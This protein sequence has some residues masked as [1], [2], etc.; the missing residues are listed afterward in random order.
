MKVNKKFIASATSAALVASAIVPVA[1]AAS[2]SDIENNTHKDAILALA[3]AGIISGYTD[4]T[5]K[6]NAQVTR[7]NVTKLLGKWLVTEGYEIP[8]DYNTV[9]RFTDVPV[10]HAD[11]ELV[12]YAALV[13]DAEV[14]NGSNGKLMQANNMSR[15]QMAVVLV[16]AIKTVYGIDLI[17][18]YKAANFESEITDF[19]QAIADYHESIT[20][21]EFAGLT[22]QKTF[23]PKGTVTR[24][25]FASF[26][27]RAIEYAAKQEVAETVEVESVT[28]VNGTLTVTLKEKAEK[29]DVK[30]FTVTQAINGG[31][32]K[33]VTPSKVELA[34][35]GLTVTLTVDKVAQTEA[36]QSVVYTVNKVAAEAFVVD[37]NKLKVESVSAINETTVQVTLAEVPTETPVADDFTVLV[38]GQKVEVS[39]VAK[40]PNTTDK[41]N[42]TIATLKGKEGSLEV[43]GKA[44]VI[45]GSEFGYDFKL[46][47]VVSVEGVDK[48]HVKVT[49]SEKVDKTTAETVATYELTGLDGAQLSGAGSKAPTAATLSADGKSVLLTTDGTMETFSNGY[50]LNVKIGLKDAKGQA[51][52][53]AIKTIFSGNG[54]ESTVAPVAVRAL[55]NPGTKEILVSF[56]KKIASPDKTKIK[57]AGQALTLA[58]SVTV[59]SGDATGRTLKI[60]L[61]TATATAFEASADQTVAFEA[62]AVKDTATTANA[63]EASSVAVVSAAKLTTATYNEET[64]KLVL[65]FTQPV[66]TSSLELEK[67]EVNGQTLAAAKVETTGT[68]SAVTIDLTTATNL[69]NIEQA[70]ETDRKVEL[71]TPTPGKNVDVNGNEIALTTITTTSGFTYTDDVTLPT[72]VGASVNATTKKLVIEFSEPVTVTT[73]SMIEIYDGT[74]KLF[75]LGSTSNDVDSVTPVKNTLEVS[76]KT[77]ANP[78]GIDT[79]KAVEDKSKLSVKVLKTTAATSGTE[80]VKDAAGNKFTH[81]ADASVAL[82]YTDQDAVQVTA[83]AQTGLASNQVKVTFD[84]PVKASDL[85]PSNFVVAKSDNAAVTVP[86]TKVIGSNNNK[87]IILT[88]DKDNANFVHGYTYAVKPNVKDIYE[89]PVTATLANN[90]FTLDTAVSAT[91]PALTGAKYEDA[92]GNFKADQGDTITL[93]YSAAVEITGD[94]TADELVL[95]SAIKLGTGFTV[96]QG[97]KVEEVVV[98]LGANAD[99]N[100]EDQTADNKKINYTGTAENAHIKGVN[101]KEAVGK[102][103]YSAAQGI[104]LVKPDVTA[105]TVTKA[106]FNDT[107]ADGVLGDGD[108]LV[109]TFNEDIKL[110]DGATVDENDFSVT[111]GSGQTLKLKA[112]QAQVAGK[113]LTVILDGNTNNFQPGTSKIDVNSTDVIADLW[114]NK[115]AASTA[116]VIEKSDTVAPKF[117]SVKYVKATTNSTDYVAAEDKLVL[118]LSEAAAPVGLGTSNKPFVIYQ[119]TKEYKLTLSADNGSDTYATVVASNGGKTLTITLGAGN[120]GSSKLFDNTLISTLTS[121]NVD[122]SVT[123]GT[124]TDANGN[125]LAPA[126]GFG[127]E[128]QK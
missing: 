36:E 87:E 39:A 86:V 48:N 31:E 83:T 14:F 13:K 11:Q 25:Q 35:D 82:A 44:A 69:T 12:K 43:N 90:T 26:L 128:I 4:G 40:A 109:I 114:G 111:L 16:R 41:F 96:Q 7:G 77:N 61:A 18:D 38:D 97:S 101:G 124:V 50:I 94:V 85:V 33:E 108:T 5:F 46:P 81:E 71:K 122:A 58:D 49:F 8:A 28:A 117:T 20:A 73:A 76:L 54:E 74:T 6:P 95:G 115:A 10:T 45:T 17:A 51:T 34:E 75:D 102:G 88:L 67:I 68:A 3:E 72:L 57:V 60:T 56:D 80:A 103:D 118:E 79:I 37:A 113:T 65:N 105:P 23:N 91:A 42:L 112:N 106:V 32:A 104:E 123:T 93:T 121:F 110:L 127:L 47:T 9:E 92:N 120:V 125:L 21:L 107:V 99:I 126:V 116:V 55:Y 66:K 53:A 63:I 1:S 29:V 19:D 119:G 2:F 98:T 89:N 15:E 64:N 62:G 22:T 70:S 24:G 78:Y 84:K 52:T 59:D 30:D 100:F 27:N